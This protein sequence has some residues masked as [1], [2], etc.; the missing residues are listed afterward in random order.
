LIAKGRHAEDVQPQSLH[1]GSRAVRQTSAVH[2]VQA[3]VLH[4]DR[5]LR[6]AGAEASCLHGYEV[7][8]SGGLQAGSGAGMLPGP[9]MLRSSQGMCPGVL[10]L[11]CG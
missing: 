8:A 11:A 6:E 1:D 10:Q 7:R 2:G 9:D 3:G 5:Q 4:E